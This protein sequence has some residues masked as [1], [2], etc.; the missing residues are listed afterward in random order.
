MADEN[1]TKDSVKQES[2]A[3]NKVIA[4]FKA[5]PK[6]I[7]TPFRNMAHE[8]R[9]VTWPSK[10]KLIRYSIIVLVFLL[11]MMVIIGLFDLGSSEL[12]KVIRINKGTENTGVTTT[13]SG[14]DLAALIGTGAGTDAA[15]DDGSVPAEDGTATG[16]DTA[17]AE[18]GTNPG[19]DETNPGT[20]TGDDN[21]QG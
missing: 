3:E 8:L 1:N 21:A 18:D 6:R 2:K 5:L 4:W 19:S 17:P 10:Q 14:D 15:A 13:L 20:D 11:V 12:M 7:A 16:S 9:R